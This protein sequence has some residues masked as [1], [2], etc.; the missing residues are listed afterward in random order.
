MKVEKESL[1]VKKLTGPMD[2]DFLV[3]LLTGCVSQNFEVSEFVYSKFNSECHFFWLKIC[4]MPLK[5]SSTS[6][7]KLEHDYVNN[8]SL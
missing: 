7:E 2:E 8:F 1:G 4:F 3:H 6:E 5:Q